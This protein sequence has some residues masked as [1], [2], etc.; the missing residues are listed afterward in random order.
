MITTTECHNILHVFCFVD[1][2]CFVLLDDMCPEGWNHH[3]VNDQDQCYLLLD[4]QTDNLDEA[5]KYC[6]EQGSTLVSIQNQA[7]ND[8]VVEQGS[9]AKWI[10]LTDKYKEPRYRW[11]D[12]TTIDHAPYLN[13]AAN[14]NAPPSLEGRSCTIL[15]PS[16][17]NEWF[18]SSCTVKHPFTCRKP[19][20]PDA[21]K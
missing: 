9:G 16:R 18:H 15:D 8:F 20:I 3:R 1:T 17:E 10:G 14:Q 4:T 12:G 11:V 6:Q 7:E 21:G 19:L 2:F 13:F 5:K